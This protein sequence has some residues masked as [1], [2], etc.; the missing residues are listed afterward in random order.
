MKEKIK[1]KLEDFAVDNSIKKENLFP[2]YEKFEQSG[3]SEK[4]SLKATKA[5]AASLSKLTDKQL[6]TVQDGIIGLYKAFI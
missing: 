4:N 6:Q 1:K 2:I 5:V 3:I